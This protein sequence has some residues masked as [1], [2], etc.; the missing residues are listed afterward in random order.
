MK[1]DS[2]EPVNATLCQKPIVSDNISTPDGLAIDWIH[3]LLYWT[4]TDYN[5]ISVVGL[6]GSHRTTLI[7]TNLDE[8]RA[9]ALDPRKG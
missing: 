1:P 7:S 8:P 4:D 9:I 5:T 6:D 2:S 3:D